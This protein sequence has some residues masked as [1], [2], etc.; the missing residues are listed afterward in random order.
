LREAKLT[1]QLPLIIVCDRFDFDHD[2]PVVV[3]F[4]DHRNLQNLLILTA[5]KADCSRVIDYVN[6]LDNNDAPDIA[7]IAINSHLYEKIFE[8][9]FIK[10]NIF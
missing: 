7:D 10:E 3:G 5:I 1:D 9:N 8:V 2:L 4:S 6:R